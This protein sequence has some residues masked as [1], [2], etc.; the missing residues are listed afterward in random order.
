LSFSAQHPVIVQKLKD[1]RILYLPFI[2]RGELLIGAYTLSNL[3]IQ[4]EI[5]EFF[6][7]CSLLVP[8]E[9]TAEI[10][11]ESAQS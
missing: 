6:R 2:A 5:E 10:Y 9:E 4:R 11:G 8:N 1:S 3:K 7:I